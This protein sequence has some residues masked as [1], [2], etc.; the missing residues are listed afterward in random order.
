MSG[1]QLSAEI[2]DTE[3]RDTVR[4]SCGRRW[5]NRTRAEADRIAFR[6]DDSPFN[7]HVVSSLLFVSNPPGKPGA[8]DA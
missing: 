2:A 5:Y 6:H 3:R 1:E 7:R 8:T 4:C